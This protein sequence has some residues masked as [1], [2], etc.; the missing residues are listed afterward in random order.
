MK[1]GPDH[2]TSL[3]PEPIDVIHAWRLNYNIGNVV[4]YVVRAGR[5]PG[6]DKVKDLEKAVW[7]LNRIVAAAKGKQCEPDAL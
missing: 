3:K 2:Y 6:E 1:P 7:Y 5:K 4:K